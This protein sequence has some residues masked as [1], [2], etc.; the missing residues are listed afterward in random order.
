MNLNE[1]EQL[2]KERLEDFYRRRIENL[3][4]LRLKQVLRRKNPYLMRATGLRTA[5]ELVE[6]LLQLHTQASDETIFGDA[7]VEP[8]AL[9]VSGGHKSSAKG[10]DIEIETERSYKAIAVKSGPNVF[11]SS[12]TARMNDEFQELHNRLRQ[13][14]Q[15]LGKQFESVLGCSYGRKNSPPTTRRRYRITAGQA[16]WQEVTGDPDFYIKLIRLMRDYPEQQRELY[17]EEWAKAVNRFTRELLNEF[18]DEE[19]ALDWEKIVRFNSSA[20]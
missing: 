20:E 4:T 8:I 15:K 1:L 5:A 12:Q 17:L 10:V 19:G 13:H 6:Y 3:R 7:F 14:L 9:A 11:N 18:A 16:F 2:I